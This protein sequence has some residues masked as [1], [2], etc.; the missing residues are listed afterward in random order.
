MNRGER[1]V[2]CDPVDC[3]GIGRTTALRCNPVEIP[4]GCLNG[5][6]RGKLPICAVCQGAE[7][8]K[9]RQGPIGCELE[10]VPA[11]APPP[12]VPVTP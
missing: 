1:A 12:P 6:P 9:R 2:Q 7:V 8:V 5:W 3:A 4:I 11:L 10:K